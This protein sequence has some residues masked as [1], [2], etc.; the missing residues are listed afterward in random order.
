MIEPS[1]S[2]FADSTAVIEHFSRGRGRSDASP[3]TIPDSG[4]PARADSVDEIYAFVALLP[5]SRCRVHMNPFIL[6]PGGTNGSSAAQNE[7]ERAN[8]DRREERPCEVLA[9]MTANGAGER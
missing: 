6:C 8:L 1:W 2:I 5:A 7:L 4:F 9:R 3:K